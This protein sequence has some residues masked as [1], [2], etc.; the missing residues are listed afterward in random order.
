MCTQ[1]SVLTYPLKNLLSSKTVHFNVQ[2]CSQDLKT[3][4]VKVVVRCCDPSYSIDPLVEEG[5]RVVV[6]P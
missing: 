6:S 5:I 4:G 3:H 1:G 2:F